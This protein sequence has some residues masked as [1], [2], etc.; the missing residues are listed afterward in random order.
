MCGRVTQ[1]SGELPGLA[2]IMGDGRDNRV[3]DPKDYVRY[4]ARRRKSSG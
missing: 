2:T 4:N 1:R 3:K